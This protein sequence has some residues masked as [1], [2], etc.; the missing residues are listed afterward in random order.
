MPVNPVIE[1]F[2][3]E[4]EKTKVCFFLRANM[5]IQCTKTKDRWKKIR[6]FMAKLYR[7]NANI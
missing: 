2:K 5:Y 4:S 7:N 3:R 6:P 1:H